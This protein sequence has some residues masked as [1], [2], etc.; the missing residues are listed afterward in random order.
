MI[1]RVGFL[2]LCFFRSRHKQTDLVKSV[3]EETDVVKCVVKETD[4]VRFT[5]TGRS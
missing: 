5:V 1:D 4:L 2:E 3:L